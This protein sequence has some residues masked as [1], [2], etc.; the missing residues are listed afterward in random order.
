MRLVT[1]ATARS[2]ICNLYLETGWLSVNKRIE[3]ASMVMMYK[4]KNI[5]APQYLI[6][7]LPQENRNRS[8]HTLR[9][10][11]KIPPLSSKFTRLVTFQN[12]FFPKS[13]DLWNALPRH[14]KAIKSLDGFKNELKSKNNEPNVLY[15]Y[16]QRWP[17]VHHTR[18]RI[19]CSKLNFDLCRNLHV[20]D[21]QHCTC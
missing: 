16:G 12:S 20:I 10:Q 19:G 6:D 8:T 4:I 9:N 2:N 17:A 11:D 13:I 7:I 21:Y 15:Y 3:N 14:T 18:L 5:S 1:G